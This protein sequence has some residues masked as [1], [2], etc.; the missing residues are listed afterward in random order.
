MLISH[1]RELLGAAATAILTLEANETWTHGGSYRTYPDAREQ[2]QELLG[3]RLEQWKREE[4]RLFQFYKTMKQRA[5]ISDVLSKR[6]NA[7]E[8]RWRRFVDA[9]P[10]P[11]PRH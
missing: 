9:G 2:R 8:T 4:R 10:P 5:A 6:A 3:D 11:A 7:A 1:D